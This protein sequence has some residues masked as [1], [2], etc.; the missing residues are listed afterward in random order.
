MTFGRSYRSLYAIDAYVKVFAAGMRPPEYESRYLLNADKPA[1]ERYHTRPESWWRYDVWRSIGQEPA[2]TE[3]IVE[4][5]S[6]LRFMRGDPDR[7]EYVLQCMHPQQRR[8]MTVL[9]RQMDAT[10]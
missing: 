7:A 10:R 1:H 9:L 8:R 3:W 5:P 4:V 2:F 6:M